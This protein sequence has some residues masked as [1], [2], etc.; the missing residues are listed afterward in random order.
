VIRG[1]EWRNSSWTIR[2][3]FPFATIGGSPEA[4]AFSSIW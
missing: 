1:L 3:S 4:T 2:M